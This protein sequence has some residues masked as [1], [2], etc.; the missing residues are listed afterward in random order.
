MKKYLMTAAALVVLSTPAFA[1]NWCRTNSFDGYTNVRT[2][3]GTQGTIL[4]Q[5]GNDR[6]VA[7]VD[8]YVDRLGDQWLWIWDTEVTTVQGWSRSSS[9]TCNGE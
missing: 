9:L 8:S 5:L 4:H 3:P 2:L 7:A 6:M 1:N